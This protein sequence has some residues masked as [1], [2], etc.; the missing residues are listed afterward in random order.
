MYNLR[1]TH[2]YLITVDVERQKYYTRWFKYDRDK[3]WLVYTQIVPDIFEPPCIYL[4]MWRVCGCPGEWA[5]ACACL[6][7][8]LLIH[9][10][11]PM[12]HIV[13]L[14]VVRPT[15]PYSSILSHKQHAFWK[16]FLKIKFVCWFSLQPLAKI[17]LILRIIHRDIVINVTSSCKV[18]VI[19]FLILIIIQRD[20][21]I[22]VTSSFKVP[23]IL[24]G[25]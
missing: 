4:S 1:V 20:I 2:I 13:A 19:F 14:F 16:I 10:A 21:V 9:Q 7:V 24:V 5:C 12:R 11:T 8:A 3:L 23:V 25:F 17:F 6:H 15:P 22:N 18:P